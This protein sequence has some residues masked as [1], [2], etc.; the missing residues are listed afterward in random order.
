MLTNDSAVDRL[1]PNDLAAEQ[2]VIGSILADPDCLT[3]LQPLIEPEDFFYERHRWIYEAALALFDRQTKIDLVTIARE[4]EDH[5]RLDDAGGPLYLAHLIAETPTSL[6]VEYYA[7]IV[8]RTALQ[9]RMI[10][11]GGQIVA[12][13]YQAGPDLEHAIAQAEELVYSLR[14]TRGRRGFVHLREVLDELFEQ[15]IAVPESESLGEAVPTG[16]IDLD[17]LLGGLKRSDLILLAARPGMGKSS[18]ALNV[19]LN[20]ARQRGATVAICSLEMSSDQLANRLLASES[21]IDSRRLRLNLLSESEQQRL[22]ETITALAELNIYIDDTPAVRIADLRARVRRLHAEHPIDLLVVDYLQ[23]IHGS[24][25]ENRVQEIGEISRSLK[26]LARELDIPV[27]ALSQL[28]RAVEQRSPHIPM[29]S[30]LRESGSLEQ[31]A[32]V[33][34]FIYREDVYYTEKE[35]EKRF[36]TKPYPRG[37]VDILVAKHRNGPTGQISLLWFEKTTRFVNLNVRD[38]G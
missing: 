25:S 4:L 32:D 1:P 9:R 7:G 33:V 11:I 3:R 20:A 29:L 13:G 27:L 22:M 34:L 24:G 10:A 38:E 5:S 19:A 26:G 37:I 17:R 36:P 23:L 14:V 15:T 16:F 8:K 2:A 18:F 28:S 30:D 6:H 31:D 21:G 35:W 12:L